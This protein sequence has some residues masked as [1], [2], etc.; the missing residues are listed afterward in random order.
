[1]NSTTVAL[2]LGLLLLLLGAKYVLAAVQIQRGNLVY[3]SWLGFRS[4]LTL[5]SERAWQL[6]NSAGVL[7]LWVAFAVCWINAFALVLMAQFLSA[8]QVVVM[9]VITLAI[10][11]FALWQGKRL[12]DQRIRQ[13]CPLEADPEQSD[14]VE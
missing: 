11:W 2:I 10:V 1:M 3:G 14:R 4:N 6:G 5:T 8:I 13:G 12:A 7:M 9:A